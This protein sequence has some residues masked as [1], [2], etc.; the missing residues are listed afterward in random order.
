MHLQNHEEVARPAVLLRVML[1]VYF[2]PGGGSYY[3]Q[4]MIA[5]VTTVFFFFTS[6]K[7]KV[8]LLFKRPRL[9]SDTPEAPVNQAVSVKSKDLK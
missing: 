3:F 2:D 9:P 1:A 5:G 4:L 8:V 6:I 7:R